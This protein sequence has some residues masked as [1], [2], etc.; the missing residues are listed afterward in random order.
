MAP[1]EHDDAPIYGRLVQERGDVPRDVRRTAED[2][3]REVE[4]TIAASR[5]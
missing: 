2:V 3:W 5:S 1:T 4:R